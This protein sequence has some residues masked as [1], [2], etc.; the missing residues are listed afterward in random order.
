MS[1]D[2]QSKER[3]FMKVLIIIPA[4]NEE[5]NIVAVVDNIVNNYPQYDYVVV[6]DGSKDFTADICRE[7]GYNLLDL[8][9]NL[10]LTGAVQAGMRY[11]L[12]NGYD[13]AIQIDAD[14]Q[15]KPE[16][17]DSMVKKMVETD[18][19]V[20]IAS[21]FLTK[22][23]E[24][25][26][27]M[28][29]SNIIATIIKLS[30]KKKITDPTSGMRLFKRNILVKFVYDMNYGPEPD[31]ISYLLKNGV[32]MEEVQVDMDERMGGQ[33]Y[34]NLFRSIKYMI[35]MCFSILIIQ[36]FRKGIK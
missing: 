12:R 1:T 7:H 3:Q 24:K 31:T 34:L 2:I 36:N 25:T 11:A 19:E 27:R 32:K 21:R 35:L 10:G 15:H 14:G 13:A 4:Y 16:Y 28:L 23:K 20:V 5:M 33:S 8:P 9:V 6:N 30:T 17:I 18:S 29:G 22:K 26:L